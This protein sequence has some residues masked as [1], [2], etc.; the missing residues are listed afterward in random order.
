MFSIPDFRAFH[1]KCFISGHEQLVIWSDF[2]CD[3]SGKIAVLIAKDR[4]LHNPV[5]K[6]SAR[7]M[8]EQRFLGL[9]YACCYIGAHE[10]A[11]TPSSPDRH[12]HRRASFLCESPMA[13]DLP[14]VE[15]LRYKR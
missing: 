15:T 6:V 1:N 13:H 3:S 7:V 11:Q 14:N 5:N 12:F 8:A 9:K 4:N 10:N 2:L